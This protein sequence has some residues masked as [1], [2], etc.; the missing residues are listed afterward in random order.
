M[1][2]T[3]VEEIFGIKAGIVWNALNQNGPSSITDLVK[4]TSVSR[5]EI[6]G[7]LGWL[8]RENKITVEMRGRARVF[9]LRPSL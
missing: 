4:A 7:A 6:Y 9:S 8:A 1:T 5:E 3:T 2:D